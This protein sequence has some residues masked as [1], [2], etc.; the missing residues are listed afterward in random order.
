MGRFLVFSL[1]CIAPLSATT[2]YVSPSGNDALPGTSVL[3]PWLTIA[4]LTSAS[5]SSGD[6]VLFKRGGTWRETLFPTASGLTFGAYG[7]GARPIITA[8]DEITS[9]WSLFSPNVWSASIGSSNPAQLWFDG[10]LG[11]KVSSVQNIVGLNQWTYSGTT[12]YVYSTSD[13]T[14]AHIEISNRDCALSMDGVGSVTFQSL[15]LK[16]GNS[17]TVFIGANMTGTQT[18]QDIVWEGSPAE[19]LI[20]LSGQQQ[21]VSSIGQNN[22]Y[23]IG[24]YGGSGITLTNSILSGNYDTALMIAGTMGPST[25]QDS[26]ITGNA[27]KNPATDTIVNWSGQPLTASHSNLLP[28]PY[29]P[30]YWNFVGLTDA[31]NNV[32]RSPMFTARAAPLIIVPYIDDRNNLNIARDVATA[33]ASYGYHLNFAVNTRLVTQTDWDALAEMRA[34]GHEI[35]AHTRTHSGLGELNVFTVRYTGAATSATM[36]INAETDRLQT[37]LSGS[38]T[39]DLNLQLSSFFA[40]ID[41]CN[42]ITTQP[43]YTCSISPMEM[44]FN[45]INLATVAQTNILTP[46]VAQADANR[47]YAYEIQ[48]AKADIETNLPGATASTFV[49]PFSSS[50]NDVENAMRS[51]GFQLNRNGISPTTTTDSFLLSHLNLFKLGALWFPDS[52]DRANPERSVAALVEGLGAVGGIIAVYSHGEDEFTVNEWNT[53]FANLKAIGG[54]CMTASEAAAYVK[55][56]GSSVSEGTAEYWNR[57]IKL[58]PNYTS[59][60]DSPAAGAHL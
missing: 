48:G 49:T 36:A 38:S 56:H 1:L 42:F 14:S 21:I 50:N 10:V 54:T 37:F 59:T 20:A 17:A 30:K 40:A 51:A 25:I 47:F 52:Y 46:Y 9:G 28:N 31:G 57:S 41:L 18:F 13:P 12:L 33:A 7:S 27:T 53:F 24:V 15:N 58:S 55:A 44:W 3:F 22:L 2:Y 23:G 6:I 39:P 16:N 29:Q 32:Y 19:G 8:A 11:T 34:A 43:N 5:L 4:H 26:T 60:S 35:L 45:P